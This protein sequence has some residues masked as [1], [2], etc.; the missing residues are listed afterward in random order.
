VIDRVRA[1]RVEKT[2]LKDS[3]NNE[4]HRLTVPARRSCF[5]SSAGLAQMPKT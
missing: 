5:A 1:D 3:G 2:A 4:L